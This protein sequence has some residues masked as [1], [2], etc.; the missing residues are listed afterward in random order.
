[1]TQTP[2]KTSISKGKATNIAVKFAVSYVRVSTLKQTKED[3]T[4]IRRQE[5]DYQR[6]LK[7]HPEYKNLEGLEIRDLGVSGR[8]NVKEGAL[9]RFLKKA[10]KGEIPANTCLVVESM[11]RLTRDE[12]Y[13]GIG[14]I[15]RLWDLNHTIAFTQG[16]WRGEILTGR[17]QG[18]FARIESSLEAASFEWEDKRARVVEYYSERAEA[19]EEGDKSFNRSRKDTK[20][21]MYPFW[22]DFDEKI[23][24]FV[25]I[26]EKVKIVQRIF[27][28][29]ETMGAKKIAYIL[30]KEGLKNPTNGTSKFLAAATIRE[31]ILKSRA[32]LG[33]KVTRG[34][35]KHDYFPP[36]ITPEQFNFV[37]SAKDKRSTSENLVSKN[38]MVN[39]FQGVVHCAECGG[40]IDVVNKNRFVCIN[41]REKGGVKELRRME[42]MYCH[43]GRAK[44]N[45]CSV[46]NPIPY[47][48]KH[49]GID[50]ELTILRQIQI[51]R[52]AE[53]FT[54]EKHEEALKI[55]I[56]KRNNFLKE[57]NTVK[58]Q[59]EKFNRAE[60]KLFEEGEIL[61]KHLRQK[62]EEQQVKY[63]ELDE[64]YN[65]AVLDI[66][67]LKRK[68]TGEQAEKDIQLRVK[69]FM[70]KG[71]FDLDARSE[72]NMWLKEMGISVEVT[73]GKNLRK[74]P[75][76]YGFEIGKGMFDPNTKKYIGLD[77][78]L[79]DSHAL[80][81]DIKQVMKL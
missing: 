60:L 72:F 21:R 5:K 45:D 66:Q 3:K 24:D 81:L 33:E 22:L 34:V 59:I 10:E 17:E 7:V 11:S 29:S 36:I 78:R 28:M 37:H 77:Q 4:G 61:P 52:W 62:R 38:K 14:L 8:K 65:R 30:Q 20:A 50:N 53:F 73:I 26:P 70:N 67:N 39:L 54:D 76:N 48:Y 58:D 1:M 6:W 57:R 68:K 49:S 43:H 51:F 18:I 40:R 74:Y 15:R 47:I 75:N 79:E 23:G 44:T 27:N 2:A 32:V 46:G 31:C 71:R 63:D 64:K 69:E 41:R 80:G 35:V 13:V 9:G 42:Q 12:P 19:I 56:E 55:E 16:S 25:E